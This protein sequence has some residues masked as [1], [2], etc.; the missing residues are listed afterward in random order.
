[1]NAPVDI[2]PQDLVIVQSILRDHVPDARVWVFGSRAKWTTRESSDL[3]LALD[4]GRAMTLSEEAALRSAF[5]ESDLPYKVDIVDRQTATPSFQAVI[6]RDGVA[7]PLPAFPVSTLGDRVGGQKRIIGGPFGSNLTAADYRTV[8]VPVIRGSNMEQDGR[9]I[10][11]EFAFVSEEKASTDLRSNTARQGDII[12]TQRGTMGQVSIIRDDDSNEKFVISQSQMAISVDE[13]CACRDFVYYYLRSPQF[14]EY[15]TQSII[16]TGV[17]HINLGILRQAPTSWPSRDVQ[18]VIAGQL[19]IL[20]DKIELNRRMN[21]TLERQ[22][23]AVFRDWFVD[24]GPVRR[25]QAGEADPV[26]IMGGLTPDPTHAT[27]LAALFPDALGDDALPVGWAMT[28]F[29]SVVTIIG[30]GTPKTSIATYWDGD[31]P[32]FSVADTPAGA[33]TFVLDTEKRITRAGLENSSARMIPAGT[34]IITARGTVGNLAVAGR[35]MT[36]NQSCYALRSADGERPYFVYLATS[37][38]IEQLQSMAHG[39]VFST[40]TRQTF[41]SVP[42]AKAGYEMIEM[43]EQ[44]VTP[45]FERIKANAVENRTLAETRDYLLPRLMSGTVRVVPQDRAA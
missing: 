36:F 18:E 32:W 28:P 3:D 21:A 22:A 1:M 16:Q 17:P 14:A 42:I 10:G 5:E 6:D 39:S 15:L 9:W 30:G 4:L 8:G 19:S 2:R 7:L 33:D 34:T 44:I 25:K 13:N 26:A 12:V 37:R 20:D 38:A 41:D 40:I 29:S 43:F 35:E 24:F 27:H 31:I 11:G 45:L 23:Q